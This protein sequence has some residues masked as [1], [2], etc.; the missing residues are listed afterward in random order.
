M[1]AL[2]AARPGR[3]DASSPRA[4]PHS[5]AEALAAHAA[6]SAIAP[7][8]SRPWDDAS[9]NTVGQARQSSAVHSAA[10]GQGRNRGRAAIPRQTALP[11]PT[12][13]TRG[14]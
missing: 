11:R 13:T 10:A 12:P 5:S 9:Q 1:R 2:S 8:S 7:R 4:T 6:Y 3:R 14:Q